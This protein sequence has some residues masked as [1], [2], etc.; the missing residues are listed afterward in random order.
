MPFH[1]HMIH[2]WLYIADESVLRVSTHHPRATD[3]ME[4]LTF[5]SLDSSVD[6]L[7]LF[8]QKVITVR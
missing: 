8:Q 7:S 6:M 4:N 1:H 5:R 2:V 3:L